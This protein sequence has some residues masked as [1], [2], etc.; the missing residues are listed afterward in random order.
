MEKETYTYYATACIRWENGVNDRKL[1][2]DDDTCICA[3]YP[4]EK[5]WC[6]ESFTRADCTIGFETAEEAMERATEELFEDMP[7]CA[8]YTGIDVDAIDELLEDALY[9]AAKDEELIDLLGWG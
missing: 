5:E 9:D 2:F 1:G 8:D 7:L 4:Y 6:Y 3:V